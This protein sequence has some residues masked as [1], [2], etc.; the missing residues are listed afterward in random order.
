MHAKHLDTAKLAYA[1]IQEADK[2]YNI[3]YI[4]HQWEK[5]LELAIKNKERGV[6]DTVLTYSLK[7]LARCDKEENNAKY[8]Q[9]MKEVEV[10]WDKINKMIKEEH[11]RSTSDRMSLKYVH[12][13]HFNNEFNLKTPDILILND[14]PTF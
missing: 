3:H 7:Y 14:F 4:Y 11:K 5:A 10:D 12:P 8:V 1:A 6:V 2:V 9:Y 13:S